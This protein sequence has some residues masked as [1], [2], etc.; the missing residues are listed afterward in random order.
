[1]LSS[2]FS[3]RKYLG[4][5]T[6]ALMKN[7]KNQKI[8][9][10]K[11]E[12]AKYLLSNLVKKNAIIN[13]KVDLVDFYHQGMGLGLQCNQTI[14]KFEVLCS[15]PENLC[16][17]YETEPPNYDS[18][19]IL[20]LQREMQGL[21]IGL[22]HEDLKFAII[23]AKQMSVVRKINNHTLEK[24]KNTMDWYLDLFLDDSEHQHLPIMW[25]ED[26][27][28]ELKGLSVH[29]ILKMRKQ[30]ISGL[31][32]QNVN[33]GGTCWEKNDLSK[34]LGIFQ[35]RAFHVNGRT[36]LLPFI[37]FVNHVDQ[38]NWDKG[39][40]IVYS[41]EALAY[42]LIACS[43]IKSGCQ[44]FSTYGMKTNE[45]KFLFYG[46]IDKK[47]ISNIHV[48]SS[49]PTSLPTAPS[50]IMESFTICLNLG[51]N[52]DFF[53]R[54]NISM[55]SQLKELNKL[56]NS[57]AEKLV[58]HNVLAKNIRKLQ[59]KVSTFQ[60]HY[61]PELL[62]DIEFLNLLELQSNKQIFNYFFHPL[63][64]KEEVQVQVQ[65][66]GT[67][68][69]YDDETM[70]VDSQSRQIHVDKFADFLSAYERHSGATVLV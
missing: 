39:C 45:D 60:H 6:S 7:T 24:S 35:S 8:F 11:I 42:Q 70:R 2:T 63:F 55:A 31:E 4:R 59:L 13:K 12:R 52:R 19:D 9:S 58:L 69:R 48:E 25:D 28:S 22:G 66:Q 5:S 50:C 15:I 27:L 49:S 43:E 18:V 10:T 32:E 68:S 20:S 64:F 41:K 29:Y 61:Q 37:D 38:D 23:L 62:T 21:Y 51:H 53:I 3:T 16:M 33:F 34:A 14:H 57:N 67:R 36:C 1:M 30:F 54:C 47:A 44:I 17:S 40:I 26:R 46:W 56:I 65:V